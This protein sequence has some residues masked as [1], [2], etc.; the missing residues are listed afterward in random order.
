MELLVAFAFSQARPLD[1]VG[2]RLWSS[3]SE[4]R[5]VVF[6]HGRVPAERAVDEQLDPDVTYR[7]RAAA[8]QTKALEMSGSDARESTE[9]RGAVKDLV[10]PV[11]VSHSGADLGTTHQR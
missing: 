4:R 8:A 10:G 5:Q 1:L 2:Q 9:G 7:E 11:V 6:A 3:G